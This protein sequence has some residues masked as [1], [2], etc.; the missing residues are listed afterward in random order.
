ME[1]GRTNKKLWRM[2]PKHSVAMHEIAFHSH[3][4]DIKYLNARIAN[5]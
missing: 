2:R 1:R 4:Q 3:V 5:Q